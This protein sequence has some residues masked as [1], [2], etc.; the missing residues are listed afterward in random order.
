MLIGLFLMSGC[1]QD[2]GEKSISP[3][4]GSTP[5]ETTENITPT[6][7]L[8]VDDVNCYEGDDIYMADV[9][10]SDSKIIFSLVNDSAND[11][12]TRYMFRIDEYADGSYKAVDTESEYDLSK[13]M[14]GIG[15]GSKVVMSLPIKNRLKEGRYR[16]LFE[17][18]YPSKDESFYAFREIEVTS[19]GTVKQ[20]AVIESAKKVTRSDWCVLDKFDVCIRNFELSADSFTFDLVNGLDHNF[21]YTQGYRITKKTNGCYVTVYAVKEN[22]VEDIISVI[23]AGQT[24]QMSL[25]NDYEL[26]AGEYRFHL[27]VI[28][29][30][31]LNTYFLPFDFIV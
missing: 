7:P 14:Y 22:P 16:L 30:N 9:Q 3:T 18:F 20:S 10:L 12:C 21:G 13:D 5:K 19:L 23:E 17:L 2:S 24:I 27:G 11:L 15:A 4:T 31:D 8:P 28:D 6:K 25:E 29:L 1:G 26:S